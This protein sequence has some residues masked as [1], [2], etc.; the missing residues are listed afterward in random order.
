MSAVIVLILRFLLAAALY[1]F[2]VWALIT[3]WRELRAQARLAAERR[4]P[5]LSVFVACSGGEFRQQLTSPDIYAGR[6]P[7]CDLP[8][9]DETVSTRHAR[10]SYH[11]RQW[12]VEDLHST[13]GTLLN[14]EPVT[15]PT[16]IISGDEVACGK[17][18]IR[19]NILA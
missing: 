10:L 4:V 19:I 9:P 6:D 7:A 18:L 2:L 14:K 1:A 8:I 15:T 17:A 5:P 11:D 3:L 12:W 13:N 16:V